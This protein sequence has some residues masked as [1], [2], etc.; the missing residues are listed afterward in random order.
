MFMPTR[1]I[2][3]IHGLSLRNDL[4]RILSVNFADKWQDPNSA[5]IAHSI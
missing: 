3:G 1:V 5:L 2:I 4:T